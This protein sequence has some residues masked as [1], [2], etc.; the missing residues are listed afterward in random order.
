MPRAGE[1]FVRCFKVLYISK[2]NKFFSENYIKI[3]EIC[4][5][6]IHVA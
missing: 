5:R 6:I 4:G 2:V 1:K 3:C